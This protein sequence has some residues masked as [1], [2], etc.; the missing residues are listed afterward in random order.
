MT[1]LFRSLFPRVDETGIKSFPMGV[2]IRYLV[3]SVAITDETYETVCDS[4]R[5]VLPDTLSLTRL[6]SE[7]REAISITSMWRYPSS[8]SRDYESRLAVVQ[9]EAIELQALL[10]GLLGEVYIGCS[11]DLDD[12]DGT[13]ED[14][15]AVTVTPLEELLFEAEI[16][17]GERK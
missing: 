8:F 1:R 10:R 3:T 14:V 2:D 17:L 12:F 16:V 15:L 7:G 4:I 13:L 6:T 5:G 9:K 11:T